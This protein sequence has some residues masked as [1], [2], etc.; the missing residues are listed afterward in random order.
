M[1]LSTT[2]YDQCFN[3]LN[4]IRTA[5]FNNLKIVCIRFS[6]HQSPLK[7]VNSTR[8]FKCGVVGLRGTGMRSTFPSPYTVKFEALP[9]LRPWNFWRCYNFDQPFLLSVVRSLILMV[10]R[11]LGHIVQAYPFG[12][13]QSLE[14]LSTLALRTHGSW[15]SWWTEWICWYEEWT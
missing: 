15:D 5:N 12:S 7:R 2:A 3:I 4:Q 14:I 1:K 9:H 6:V 8:N 10:G 11:V 13:V